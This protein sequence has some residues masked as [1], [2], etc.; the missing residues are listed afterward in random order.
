MRCLTAALPAG[1][2]A[3]PDLS[4]DGQRILFAYARHYPDLAAER[5][6]ADGTRVPED[7]YYH[8]YEMNADGTGLRRLTRG[9]YDD[10]DGRYL[11]DGSIAFLS[12]RKGT[13]VQS[14]QATAESTR[15]AD[16]PMSYVRCGGDN[17]RPVPVFTLHL[18]DGGRGRLTA[19][20]RVREFRVGTFPRRR[21]ADP[22]HPMGLHRSV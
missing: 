9:K 15:T 7:A 6:K 13:A 8:L 2:F 22:L 20:I 14:T 4:T 5:N 19:V 16:L 21:W 12:T 10:F 17:W 18:M 3:G 11:P 1:S